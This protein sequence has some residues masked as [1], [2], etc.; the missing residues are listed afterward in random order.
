VIEQVA[1]DVFPFLSREGLGSATM[2]EK[3]IRLFTDT[4][5]KKLVE[6]EIATIIDWG[7]PFV[8]ATY[9][10]EGDCHLVLHY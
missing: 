5:K 1:G 3:L 6:L 8:I 10:L 4:Q 9:S 7:R 2:M